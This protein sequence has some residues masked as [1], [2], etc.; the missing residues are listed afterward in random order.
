MTCG[1]YLITNKDTNQVYVGKSIKISKNVGNNI[2]G[3]DFSIEI[4]DDLIKYAL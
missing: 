3:I 2:G 4:I 1:I